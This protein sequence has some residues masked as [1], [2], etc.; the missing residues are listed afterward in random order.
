M[1][2]GRPRILIAHPGRIYSHQAA[3][4]LQQAGL[5][6][7]YATGVPVSRKQLRAPW[8]GI[9]RLLSVH[10]DVDIP[11]SQT[12]I[13][14]IAPAVNRLFG[15]YLPEFLFGPIRYET[16][17][18]FDRWVARLILKH[19]F[20]AVIASENSAVCTFRAAKSI[21]TKCILDAA[22]LHHA[23]QD[24]YYVSA[25]P[26]KYKARVDRLKDAEVGAR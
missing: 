15:R 22:D 24:R 4:A 9:V 11:L 1:V 23:E 25:L 12:R 10:E 21:G 3:L 17:R 13:N 14:L 19:R 16:F 5:L 26:R 18:V 2:D 20:D 8:A 6:G 7:C